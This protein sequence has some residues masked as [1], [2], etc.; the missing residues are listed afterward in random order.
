MFSVKVFKLKFCFFLFSL[1]TDSK[2]IEKRHTDGR[3]EII[4]PDKT[5]KYVNTDG[6]EETVFTDGIVQN[7]D[8]SGVRTVLFPNGQKEV[9][10]NLFKV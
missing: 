1:F 3:T 6:S 4:F 8:T 5:I 9:H 7:V 2:Q 10:T